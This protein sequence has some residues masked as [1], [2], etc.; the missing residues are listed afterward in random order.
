MD[1]KREKLSRLNT[2]DRAVRRGD[3]FDK[4]LSASAFRRDSDQR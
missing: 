1:N 2:S 3:L 4:P